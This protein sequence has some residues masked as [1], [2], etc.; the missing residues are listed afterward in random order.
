MKKIVILSNHHAYTYNFRRE[1]IQKFLDVGFKVYLVLPYG[2]KV[3]L[4]KEMGCEFIDL[5]LDRRGMN[6]ITDLKLLVNYNKIIKQIKPDAVLSYTVK[7]NIYGGIVS[8]LLN[9]SFFLYVNRPGL[10]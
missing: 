1:I 8:R 3:E 10:V 2:E 4:L 9:I 6:P 5:P 7:T